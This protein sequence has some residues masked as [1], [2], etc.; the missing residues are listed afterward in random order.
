MGGWIRHRD[1]EWV[2]WP[3]LRELGASPRTSN[4][5]SPPAQRDRFAVMVGESA[6]PGWYPD[7]K[8]AA[9]EAYWTGTEWAWRRQKPTQTHENNGRGTEVYRFLAGLFTCP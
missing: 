1:D 4:R 6:Q 7:P 5:P 3:H 8:D 2:A 9:S